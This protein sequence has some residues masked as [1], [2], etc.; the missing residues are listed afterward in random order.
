MRH[1]LQMISNTEVLQSSFRIYL[2]KNNSK[3]LLES[4][5]E[6]SLPKYLARSHQTSENTYLNT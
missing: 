3:T 1:H 6:P 2:Q 5:H 4:S